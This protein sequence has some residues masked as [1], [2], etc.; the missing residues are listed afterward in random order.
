MPAKKKLPARKATAKRPLSPPPTTAGFHEVMV[1]LEEIRSQ[2]RATIET[3]EA[4]YGELRREMHAFRDE[5]RTELS[6]IRN[7]VQGHTGDIRDLRTDV[8]EVKSGLARVETGLAAV[9]GKA[10]GIETRV[11]KMD[12]KVDKLV[13]LDE[14]VTA[15]ERSRA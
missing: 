4:R 5:F 2:N 9:E 3:V 14:R 6:L 12:T 15:L 11:G 13:G 10:G 8:R 1:L 7:V